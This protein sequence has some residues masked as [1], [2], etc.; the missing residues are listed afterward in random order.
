MGYLP[1]ASASAKKQQIL[2]GAHEYLIPNRLEI[3]ERFG[4]DLVIGKREGYRIWDVD[5]HELLDFHLNGGTYNVGHRNPE[6]LAKLQESLQT[7]DVGNHHFASEARVSL[8]EKLAQA[9]GLH[10]SLFTAS[11][12]EANDMAIKSAR[13]YTGRRKIVALDCAFHGRSGLSGAAGDD[14][15][16]QYFQSDYPQEFIRVPFNDLAAMEQALAQE[17][18]AAVLMET[19]PA[20][21]GFPVPSDD[22]LPGVRK[23]CYQ[24][25]SLYIA[26]EVQTGLCRS[27]HLW[28]IDAWG[29]KPDMLV[30][31]KGLSAG[32]Y[33]VSA[34]V[35]KKEVGAW[36]SE[37]G[38]GHVSTF[39]GAEPGCI[40]GSAVLE[41]CNT[42]E[43]LSHVQTVS[44]YLYAG[45]QDIQSRHDYLVGINRMGL[46]MGLKFDNPNGGIHMMKALYDRGLWAIFAGFDASITQFKGGLFIDKAYCDLALE[47]VESAINVAKEIKGDGHQL[48]IGR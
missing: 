11:A 24:Y 21:Y 6:I 36:L 25:G 39:G 44:D 35:M 20:T 32:L 40:V 1:P 22:Y 19:I 14:S 43:T 48:S 41:L 4:I 29:V 12:S 30:T 23:L 37:N 38:W 47:R 27:G 10:Y 16:A 28:A 42:P 18:V 3:F 13:R 26:D 46:I 7:L 15:A 31:G 8:A 9:T 45:L 33:P 34:L 2:T 17:D 5:G